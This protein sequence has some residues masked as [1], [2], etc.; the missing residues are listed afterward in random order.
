MVT[1]TRRVTFS[2]AHRY[3]LPDVSDDENARLYG[4]CANPHGH[5]HDYTCEVT[6]SGEIDPATG[7]VLNLADL[8]R[9]LYDVIVEPLDGEFLTCFHPFTRGQVPTSENLVRAI[10]RGVETGLTGARLRRVR[11]QEND[12]LAAECCRQ[13]EELMVFLTRTYEFSASHRLHS[14][15]LS[16]EKNHE[17]FGKCNNPYGH[18]HNYKLEVTVCGPVNE[19]TGLMT[20][21]R[22][23][24]QVV[25]EEV[26]DRY[27]HK[28]LNM[29]TPEFRE[30][31][32][33]SENLVKVIWERLARRVQH[34]PLYRVT[35]RET[36]R[37]IFAYY[38]EGD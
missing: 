9:L 12:W 38:G 7:M 35:V 30:L 29:D 11:L 19:R 1:M 31:N 10:W 16:D 21:L 17:I 3:D 27:D 37:N 2:A 5:G 24:D 26:L 22:Y 34:P 32:P 4:L 33:T 36:E 13:D 20:D 8:K 14:P 25:Q 6:V 18:G 28:N 15:H 23:L